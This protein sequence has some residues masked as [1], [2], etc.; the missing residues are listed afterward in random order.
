MSKVGEVW[1]PV[2]NYEGLYEVSN[3]GKVRSVYRYKR[4]LKPMISNSGYERVDLFKDKNRK[5]FSVHRLVAMAFVDNPDKKPFVN[6]KDE[7]KLNNSA[8]NLEWVSHIE[9][10]RYG[11]AVER[12]TQH[13][14][15][16]KRRI[17]NAGQIKSCS[18][19]IAQY[20]KDG[21]FVRNWDSASECARATGFSISGI[22]TVVSGKRNSIFGYVFKEGRNDLS[23]R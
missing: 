15:Y 8:E 6:H 18:K 17:N 10:C 2:P 7:N 3:I 20:T 22:R 9:N 1:K 19:P 12:R 14:D 23:L 4:V 21:K 5:Q 16:S 11:T 13:F